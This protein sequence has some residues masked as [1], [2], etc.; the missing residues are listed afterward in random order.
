MEDPA[1]TWDEEPCDEG[2]RATALYGADGQRFVERDDFGDH[3]GDH[4]MVE[5]DGGAPLTVITTDEEAESHL[6]SLARRRGEEAG[7]QAHF[8]AELFRLTSW[9]DQMLKPIRSRQ[10]WHTG[11][12]RQYAGAYLQKS[13]RLVAGTLKLV[14]GRERIDVS[15]P[16]AFCRRYEGTE[17][18]RLKAEPD[19][20]AIKAA[21]EKDGIC[22]DFTDLVRGDS[23]WE[24]EL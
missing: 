12:L 23:H 8:E 2:V 16:E 5:V 17:L 22:P 15:D 9:R 20:K 6:R 4:Y 19:K 1:E 18:V 24:I 7:I 21:I 11:I 3:Y 14:K 10:E 13:K